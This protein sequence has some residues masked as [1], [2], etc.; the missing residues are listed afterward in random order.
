MHESRLDERVLD[1]AAEGHL[2]AGLG[3]DVAAGV[4]DPLDA[5]PRN[6]NTFEFAAINPKK[7]DIK[8][9]TARDGIF[10]I[11]SEPP[12]IWSCTPYIQMPKVEI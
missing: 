7:N 2:T 12:G 3:V 5:H 1:E 10:L 6:W 4:A 11:A 9:R 8:G